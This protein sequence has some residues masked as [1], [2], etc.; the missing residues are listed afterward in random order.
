MAANSHF[1]PGTRTEHIRSTPDE[2]LP[3]GAAVADLV[4]EWACKPANS[5][6]AF[7][8]KGAGAGHA[9]CYDPE[10]EE[11][12]LDVDRCFGEGYDP[13]LLGDFRDPAVRLDWLSV[14][15]A[16][17]HEAS[18]ARVSLWHNQDCWDGINDSGS[19]LPGF[20][21]ELVSC[22]EEIRIEKAALDL[23]AAG[24][25]ALRASAL[26]FVVSELEAERKKAAKEALEPPVDAEGNPLPPTVDPLDPSRGMLSLSRL[27]ILVTARVD[28]G[29]LEP[30]DAKLVA[31]GARAVL[32]DKCVDRLRALWKQAMAHRVDHRWEPLWD[33]AR[34][35]VAVLKEEG[36]DPS[37]APAGV[38]DLLIVLLGDGNAEGGTPGELP[39]AAR[40]VVID[41]TK[42]ANDLEVQ[43][44]AEAARRER[45]D[46]AKEARKAQTMSVQVFDKPAGPHGTGSRSS[47]IE[48]RE[49]SQ[50]EKAAASV[51]ATA[52]E[53]AQYR[54]K[55][56]VTRSSAVPPGRLRSRGAM[57]NA[58][59]RSQ[60][61]MAIADPFTQRA[62]KWVDEPTLS[63]GVM[64]DISGS[65][66][67]VMKEMGSISWVLPEAVNR[68]DGEFAMVYFGSGV[69]SPSRE[70]SPKTVKVFS[71]SDGTEEFESGML[72]LQG[73]LELFGGSGARILVVVSDLIHRYDQLEA[74]KHWFSRL[75]DDGV[76]VL[77]VS[78]R[79]NTK[80]LP[81]VRV[82]KFNSSGTLA[83]ARELGALCV[84]E[85]AKASA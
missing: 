53:S 64:V 83:V 44:A 81:G 24:R 9:A 35:W 84:E 38:T 14:E 62:R 8:G 74:E 45:E 19:E 47:L 2:W 69:F 30:D 61:R 23:D 10:L 32:G 13:E 7:V 73:K 31:D 70:H 66:S 78:P 21:Y 34:G 26:E 4:N 77:V 18:H 52:L 49:P 82:M 57:A 3:F 54:E 11:V 33:L 5:I 56:I 17:R 6:L 67:R 68:V 29:V 28:A 12:Q 59:A 60:G 72:A 71:A 50:N 55:Q 39:E 36:Q 43:V 51:L 80:A 1:G 37:T 15:G 58:A 75:I 48:E 63:V 41:A 40:V 76:T 85:L 27:L 16:L 42:E 25:P 22:F 46:E 20:E 79:D 65:M